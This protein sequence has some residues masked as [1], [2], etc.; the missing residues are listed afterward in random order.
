MNTVNTTDSPII[1][2]PIVNSPIINSPIVSAPIENSP[3]VSGPA[4]SSSGEQEYQDFNPCC[5]A[6]MPAGNRMFYFK[7]VLIVFCV[8][9]GA[10]Y[11][12]F[13][14]CEYLG[15]FN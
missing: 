4:V 11:G 10:V 9:G 13:K 6:G 14:L 12:L 2:S 5:A 1:N 15:V 8:L 3:I 7:F